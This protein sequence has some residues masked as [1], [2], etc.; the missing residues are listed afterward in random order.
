VEAICHKVF[1]NEGS[2]FFG[3]TVFAILYFPVR[4]S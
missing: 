3:S 2:E 4:V 1:K